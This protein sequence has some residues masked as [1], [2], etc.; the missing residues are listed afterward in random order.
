MNTRYAP[1]PR[2]IR[3]PPLQPS[4]RPYRPQRW[5]V[6][7]P[8][9]THPHFDSAPSHDGWKRWKLT[10]TDAT[11]I[12]KSIGSGRLVGSGIPVLG[13]APNALSE[14]DLPSRC[15][16]MTGR[17]TI[18]ATEVMPRIAAVAEIIFETSA[19]SWLRLRYRLSR[20]RDSSSWCSIGSTKKFLSTRYHRVYIHARKSNSCLL[21]D[22]TAVERAYSLAHFRH[23]LTRWFISNAMS[24]V[25][26]GSLVATCLVRPTVVYKYRKFQLMV[27]LAFD[28]KIRVSR[29]HFFNRSC[30][31]ASLDP[32]ALRSARR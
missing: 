31:D 1:S 9:D 14:M 8:R 28:V 19:S 18:D 32:V 10:R 29:R 4:V 30:T 13:H 5:R 23:A 15:D 12:R 22:K 25:Y 17:I 7:H 20:E 24:M 6:Q 16:S 26:P 21:R 3:S 11:A 2:P 27:I